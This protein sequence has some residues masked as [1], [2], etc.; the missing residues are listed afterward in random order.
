[1]GC[2]KQFRWDH[3]VMLQF[4]HDDGHSWH[5]V[6]E[7]CYQDCDGHHTEGSIFYTGTHGVWTL[8]VIPVDQRM[9]VQ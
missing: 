5:L 1:M 7:P 4:S 8:V 6:E 2:G 9:A 3:P